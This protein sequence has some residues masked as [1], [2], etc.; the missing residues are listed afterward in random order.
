[1]KLEIIEHCFGTS[2]E[3]D[4]INVCDM[5]NIHKE[6]E[7]LEKRLLLIEELKANISYIHPGIFIEIANALSTLD[8][9]EED[10]EDG[11]SDTCEQCGGW[12]SKS[13]YYKTTGDKD[14]IINIMETDEELGLYDEPK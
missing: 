7:L 12:N 10:T 1:M 11:Y 4:G 13:T 9:F 6:E 8:C 3:V 2:I 14:A 5:D